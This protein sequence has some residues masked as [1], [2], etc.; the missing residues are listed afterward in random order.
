MIA[1]MIERY[2]FEV[3]REMVPALQR[4]ESLAVN[5]YIKLEDS[6]HCGFDKVWFAVLRE[7]DY[8]EQGDERNSLNKTTYKGAKGWLK[9]FAHL[10]KDGVPE[11]Y[12]PKEYIC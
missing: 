10:C 3:E 1:Q 7:V 6:T 9:S 12:L 8:F 4:L 5:R 11:G 2:D